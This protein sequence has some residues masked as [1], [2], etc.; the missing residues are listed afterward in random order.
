MSLAM[1]TAYKQGVC[2][3][4]EGINTVILCLRC[5]GRFKRLCVQRQC[6]DTT[7]KVQKGLYTALLFLWHLA[8]S[9]GRVKQDLCD[10]EVCVSQLQG[11]AQWAAEAHAYVCRLECLHVEA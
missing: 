4:G 11:K 5:A 7:Y 1:A 2:Q 8:R 10:A 6:V 9:K 3:L